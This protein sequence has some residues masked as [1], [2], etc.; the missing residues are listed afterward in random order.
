MILNER[1]PRRS[2]RVEHV[3]RKCVH[4]LKWL[5]VFQNYE[6]LKKGALKNHVNESQK[7]TIA[8]KLPVRA[9]GITFSSTGEW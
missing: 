4:Q 8:K 7:K 2:P 3:S 6:I 9:L 1:M 5:E